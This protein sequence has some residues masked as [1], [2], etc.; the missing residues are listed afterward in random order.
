MGRSPGRIT[1]AGS[2]PCKQEFCVI[3]R[4]HNR[5]PPCSRH[6]YVLSD[7]HLAAAF[8]PIDPT[9]ICHRGN[10][11]LSENGQCVLGLPGPPPICARIARNAT[12]APPISIAELWPRLS[13]MSFCNAT[14]SQLDPDRYHASQKTS[15]LPRA[16]TPVVTHFLR[17]P[18]FHTPGRRTHGRSCSHEFAHPR[19]LH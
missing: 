4:P 7:Q 3:A 11:S 19:S 10:A 2:T 18:P 8:C 16:D 1:S 5:H 13:A 17:P 14:P 9:G 6:G 15:L 12:T